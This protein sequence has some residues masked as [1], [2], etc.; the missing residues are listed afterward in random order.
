MPLLQSP[1][2]QRAHFGLNPSTYA[3]MQGL[4]D[5]EATAI[6]RKKNNVGGITIP[7]I[8]LYYKPTIINTVWHWQKNRSQIN[9]TE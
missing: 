8:K 4:F 7:D 9:G 5:L 1:L 2:F 6:M 3:D